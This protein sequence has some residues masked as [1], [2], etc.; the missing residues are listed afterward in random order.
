MST[1]TLLLVLFILKNWLYAPADGDGI[2]LRI[3]PTVDRVLL[4]SGESIKRKDFGS[5]CLQLVS[6]LT[7]CLWQERRVIT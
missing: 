6:N 4:G 2:I 3:V 1:L 7:P 5:L